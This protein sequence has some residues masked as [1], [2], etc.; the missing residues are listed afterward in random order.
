MQ[1][2]KSRLN[3]KDQSS[4]STWVYRI[5]LNVCLAYLKKDKN[6]ARIFVSDPIEDVVVPK[7]RVNDP[8]EVDLLY[9]AIKQLSEV[10]RAIIIL[11]LEEIPY[12]EIGEMMN[13]STS[14]V[15][16]RI[17]RIKAKLKMIVNEKVD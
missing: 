7:E 17:N 6:K 1:I 16:V 8:T 4:W 11:Y 2:W 10:E 9:H 3:F 5:S 14:N 13:I 12:R 15:G